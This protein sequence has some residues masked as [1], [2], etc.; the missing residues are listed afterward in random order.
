LFV[1]LSLFVFFLIGAAVQTAQADEW[2]ASIG[3]GIATLWLG[4]GAV[5]SLRIGLFARAHGIVMRG[6]FR[7]TTIAWG[8]VVA[9]T[10]G[11]LT[12]GASGLGGITPIVWRRR[13]GKEEPQRVELN[14]AGS[15][16]SALTEHA[17]ADLNAH[18]A[19]WRDQGSSVH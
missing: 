14:V 17:V 15:F 2:P 1:T 3:F 10:S 16:A 8:D 12:S 6:P 19:L 9:I 5:R 11:P 13:V 18:L 7:T 4:V